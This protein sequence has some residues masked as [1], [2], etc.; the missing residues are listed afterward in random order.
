MR[1]INSSIVDIF[2]GKRNF[3]RRVPVSENA[4]CTVFK[5]GIFLFLEQTRYDSLELFRR[6]RIKRS[7]D[8]RTHEVK[9]WQ[10]FLVFYTRFRLVDIFRGVLGVYDIVPRVRL[11]ES[12]LRSP[13]FGKRRVYL[14]RLVVITHKV[15]HQRLVC[16]NFVVQYV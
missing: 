9:F 10:I 12:V 5:H 11:H 14:Q 6:N 15:P 8:I 13:S 3:S 2:R 4:L 1:N 16:S 7:F